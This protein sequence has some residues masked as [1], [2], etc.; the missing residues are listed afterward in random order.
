MTQEATYHVT[1]MTCGGC[2]RSVTRAVAALSPDLRVEVDLAR[3]TRR[4]SGEHSEEPVRL[5]VERAGFQF[6]G[7]A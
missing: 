4:G 2:V 5:A 1:G 6:D 3:G 7:P